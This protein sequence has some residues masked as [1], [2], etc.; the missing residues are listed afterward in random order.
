MRGVSSD[1]VNI[2]VCYCSVFDE[3]WIR[4]D[5]DRRPVPVKQCPIASTPYRQ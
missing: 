4:T 3:C 5:Q 2:S 1:H